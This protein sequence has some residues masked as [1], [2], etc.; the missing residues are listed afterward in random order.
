MDN[1]DHVPRLTEAQQK[2]FEDG[3]FET[4]WTEAGEPYFV[5]A[6]GLDL[7]EFALLAKAFLESKKEI[8]HDFTS[9]VISISG[10]Q[11]VSFEYHSGWFLE[12]LGEFPLT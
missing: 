9:K 11:E 5:I 3:L 7:E 10:E 8:A 2:K 6:D 12:G 4:R 1:Q